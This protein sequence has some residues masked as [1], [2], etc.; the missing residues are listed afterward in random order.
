MSSFENSLSTQATSTLDVSSSLLH[1]GVACTPEIQRPSFRQ[2]RTKVLFRNGLVSSKCSR[3][4]KGEKRPV[5]VE[6]NAEVYSWDE[7]KILTEEQERRQGE[8]SAL[9]Y[10]DRTRMGTIDL[11]KV[12][13]YALT[14]N[15]GRAEHFCKVC[16]YSFEMIIHVERSGMISFKTRQV[17]AGNSY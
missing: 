15:E 4:K 5:A 10:G 1:S 12:S 9:V 3:S 8:V 11:K 16:S 7:I 17:L 13:W 2:K 14:K 6:N